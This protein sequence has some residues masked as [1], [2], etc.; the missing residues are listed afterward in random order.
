ML[1]VMFISVAGDALIQVVGVHRFLGQPL[2]GSHDGC[3]YLYFLADDILQRDVPV[4]FD[5]PG[6]RPVILQ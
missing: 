4:L 6:I 1:A 2:D 3:E 5:D